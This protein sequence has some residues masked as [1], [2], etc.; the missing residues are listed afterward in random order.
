M[1]EIGVASRP[2]PGRAGEA[3][4]LARRL[5]RSPLGVAGGVM[6]A[7]LYA[8]ALLA[9]FVAPY[10]E[11]S[12]DRSRLYQ[13][14]QALR[15]VDA[16][17]RFHL[18]PFVHPLR[19]AVGRFGYVEDRSR[20]LPVRLFVRGESYRW[21]GLVP[22]DRHLVGVEAPERVYLLGGD[23]FGRDVLSRLVFGAQVSLTVGLLGIAV[24][25]VIGML[26]GGISGYYGG[27]V[28]ALLMRA[29]ELLLSIPGLYLILALRSVFPDDL[30]SRQ[31]YLGI[32]GILALLGWA[33]LARVIRGL[34]LSLREQDFVSAAVALGAEPLSVIVRHILP[35]TLSFAIVAAT[36]AVPGYILGEVVLSFLGVGIQEPSASWGNMLNQARSLTTLRSFPWLLYGPG[37]AIFLTVMSWN[38][39]GDALRDA[40]DPRERSWGRA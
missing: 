37:A 25:F 28:D 7:G 12:S 10:G 23:G 32:V 39:L 38:F 30:P 29:S 21:L 40:L 35:N 33:S 24:S 11:R 15:W 6:L 18:R 5:G 27:A 19:P 3:R 9:P 26:L 22:G 2:G 16:A 36:L 31:V 1:T 4:A 13:P 17:G 14:P 20:V 8:G 34:V